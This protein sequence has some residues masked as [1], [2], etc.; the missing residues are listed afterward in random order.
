MENLDKKIKKEL[1][2]D[3]LIPDVVNEKINNAYD[4][5]IKTETKFGDKKKKNKTFIKIAVSTAAC[6]ILVITLGVNSTA[7]ADKM[8]FMENV[9]N[10]FRS[11]SNLNFKQYFAT[12]NQGDYAEPVNIQKVNE[13]I[14]ITIQDVYCDGNS[15][16]ITY[17]AETKNDKFLESDG[18]S[19]GGIENFTMNING[20]EIE[21]PES[22]FLKKVKDNTYVGMQYF[23]LTYYNGVLPETFDLSVGFKMINGMNS[24]S[25]Q[26]QIINTS[27]DGNWNFDINVINN[28]TE[29]KVYESNTEVNG[30]ILK[31]I[32]MT[33]G[34]TEI[35]IDI[36]NSMG[37]SAHVMAY[38]NNGNKFNPVQSQDLNSEIGKLKHVIFESSSEDISYIIVKIVDKSTQALTELAEFKVELN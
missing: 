20:Q 14:D 27:I 29:N 38:D 37:P 33:P 9:F 31:K 32:E 28:T 6:F 21:Y 34:T 5:I 35:L 25:D 18:L 1:D 3:I 22:P 19:L 26:G 10:L 24:R 12:G 4:I 23:S 15:I 16:F 7:F 8:T 11:D 13:D 36:P 17:I 30:A 2:K